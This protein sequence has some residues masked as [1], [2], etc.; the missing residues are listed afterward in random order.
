MNNLL[1]TLRNLGPGRLATLA[2][3]ALGLVAF[4][5][6]ISL[7]LSAPPMALLYSDLE[8]GDSS[9]IATKLQG[10]NI[11]Y[12]VRGDGAQIM[13]PADQVQNLRMTLAGEGLPAGG[14][15]GYEI[16]DRTQSLG[17]SNFVQNVNHLRALEGELARTIKTLG[18]VKSARVHL[19]LPQR[20]LFSRTRQEASASVILR[21]KGSQRLDRPQIQSVQ[22]LV[23]SAVPGLSAGRISIVD[24]RGTLLARG[25]G[26]EGAGGATATAE[27]MRVAYESRLARAVEELVERSTGAGKVRAEVTAEFDYDRVTINTETFDPDSQVARSTQ[28]TEENSKSREASTN[29]QVGVTP[30]LPE[31]QTESSAAGTGSQTSRTDSTTNFEISKT[32]KS[33]VREG[34]QVKRLSVAV[35]VDGNYDNGNYTPRTPD[36]IEQLT[37]LV[38]SAVGFNSDRGDTL[39]VVNLRFADVA[40]KGDE[41]SDLLF[42]F[43]RA[44]L[45]RLGEVVILSIVGLL[46]LLLVVRPLLARLFDAIKAGPATAALPGM[47]G[48][49]GR[50]AGPA[51]MAGAIAG[52]GGMMVGPDGAPIA[53]D[54]E[55]MIDISSIE[56]RVKASSLKKIGEIVEKHPEEAVSIVRNWMYQEN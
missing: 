2:V 22:H 16:F 30:N 13:V 52:P 28:T 37:R 24:D 31:G 23:A 10:M 47:P 38:R 55:S 21:M 48:V 25:A 9:Q 56:G 54:E 35:L 32:V 26:G 46:A 53:V 11:P 20:D 34:G 40:P 17:T 8:M 44:E 1:Q 45:L 42:G 15:I 36:Q 4:F 7:R 41:V 5:V 29:D 50:L 12:Q 19:V 49:A 18:Q 14:S 33:Q 43:T 27:E 6:Y 3:S 39:E 51:G